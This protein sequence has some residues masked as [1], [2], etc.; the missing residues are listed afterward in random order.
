M[1]ETVRFFWS[2]ADAAVPLAASPEQDRNPLRVHRSVVQECAPAVLKQL[3]AGR[4]VAAAWESRGQIYLILCHPNLAK[5]PAENLLVNT[6]SLPRVVLR[7]D[8]WDELS[9]PTRLLL[10]AFGSETLFH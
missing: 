2:G 9:E 5:G 3:E 1:A 4:Y 10:K 8:D 7:V 6:T